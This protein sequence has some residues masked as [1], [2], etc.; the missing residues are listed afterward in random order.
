MKRTALI[1]GILLL[2][3]SLVT[4]AEGYRLA[5][6]KD[7]SALYDML[8][9]GSY[10]LVFGILLMIIGL[11]HL[12][13]NYRRSLRVEKLVVSK[14]MRTRVISAIGVLV[15]YTVL[16]NIIGYLLATIVFFFL[17][18]RVVGVKSWLTH[19]T[20]TFAFTA[21]FYIVFI[22]FGNMIFPRG[23]FIR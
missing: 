7:P 11:A 5:I 10:V 16:I 14:E 13:V 18:L 23:I 8:G 9:P 6:Y 3:I 21:V 1:E 19:V 15:I 17:E 4:M 2:V 20:L 12:I 22:H